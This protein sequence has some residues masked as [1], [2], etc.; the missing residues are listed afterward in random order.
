MTI[1]NWVAEWHCHRVVK[2]GVVYFIHLLIEFN[3]L[4]I[5][6]K[7][8]HFIVALYREFSLRCIVQ[9]HT[10]WRVWAFKIEGVFMSTFVLSGLLLK[11]RVQKI[12][13]LRWSPKLVVNTCLR[14]IRLLKVGLSGSY[15]IFIL[16]YEI[17]KV[18][19]WARSYL[20]KRWRLRALV[21]TH[22]HLVGWF[23]GYRVECLLT[24]VVSSHISG[25]LFHE[26][27]VVRTSLVII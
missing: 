21:D 17:N 5:V 26:R 20:I 16:R 4:W 1:L 11:G 27:I 15:L 7:H 9:R 8:Y 18:L 13:V 23:S 6:L 3:A 12:I 19:R 10:R 22:L 25:L 24:S 14:L 2:V